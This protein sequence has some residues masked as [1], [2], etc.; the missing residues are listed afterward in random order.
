MEFGTWFKKFIDDYNQKFPS[1]GIHFVSETG[2]AYG[3]IFYIKRSFFSRR[4]FMDPA[5]SVEDNR[6]TEKDPIYAR[7]VVLQTAEAGGEDRMLIL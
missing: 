4:V 5:R 6:V 1:S 7:R 3:W 2:E